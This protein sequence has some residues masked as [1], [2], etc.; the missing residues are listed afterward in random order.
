MEWGLEESPYVK[1]LGLV[2][3][4]RSRDGNTFAL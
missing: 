1:N 4:Y 2:T 3:S